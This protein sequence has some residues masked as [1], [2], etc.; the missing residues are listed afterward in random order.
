MVG[1]APSE[2]RLPRSVACLL[3]E[4]RASVT[5]MQ[6][7]LSPRSEQYLDE[8]VSGGLFPSKE[9]ALEAAIE[10]L[11]EKNAEIPFVSDEDMEAVEQAIE[12]S[13]AGRSSPMTRADWD[14]LRR[15]ARDAAAR[16]SQSNT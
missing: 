16:N 7:E 8:V 3:D 1:S 4:V 14:E 12:S 10:A 5:I 9:A 2:Y 13:R 11:R 15:V 6:H